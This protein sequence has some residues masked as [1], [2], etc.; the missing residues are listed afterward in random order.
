MC[1]FMQNGRW[2]YEFTVR[3]KRTRRSSRVTDRGLAEQ[4]A[5]E[6]QSRVE[7][8]IGNDSPTLEALEAEKKAARLPMPTPTPTGSAPTPISPSMTLKEA[9]LLWLEA[10]A[11]QRRKPKTL[12]CNRAYL[13]NLLR[14][15]GD[16]PLADFHAGSIREY[17]T[18][19]QKA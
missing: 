12:E 13:W 16:I 8:S 9:G 15:F 6:H 7:Q 3:G 11:W 10:K 2:W 5:A 17:Q 4:I 1:T 18:E 19:R 14:Y